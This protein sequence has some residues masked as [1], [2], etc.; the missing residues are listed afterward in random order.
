M[1]K[2][3]ERRHLSQLEIALKSA[4]SARRL[5][6]VE[7]GRC[8]P[9]RETVQRLA[10]EL[11]LPLREGNHLLLAAGYAPVYSKA[12]LDSP[13][14]MSVLREFN[15]SFADGTGGVNR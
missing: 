3:W 7:N 9:S 15:R 5:S 13:E 4:I 1:H 2:W 12:T 11:D 14:M 8:T 10:E 6:F